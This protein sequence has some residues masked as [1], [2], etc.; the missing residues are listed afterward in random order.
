MDFGFQGLGNQTF[1]HARLF[2][3]NSSRQN[4]NL[5]PFS[6]ELPR[7]GTFNLNLGFRAASNPRERKT[8]PGLARGHHWLVGA[9]N[10]MLLFL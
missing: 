9:V 6:A 8:V 7:A 10:P 5:Q 2:L 1:M 3:P 4:Y